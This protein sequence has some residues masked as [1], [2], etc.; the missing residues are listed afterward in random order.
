MNRVSESNKL[1]SE[2]EF[3]SDQWFSDVVFTHTLEAD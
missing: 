3:S 2:T 1:E